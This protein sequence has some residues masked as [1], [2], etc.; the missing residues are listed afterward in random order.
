MERRGFLG[1]RDVDCSTWCKSLTGQTAQLGQSPALVPCEWTRLQQENCL[2]QLHPVTERAEFKY[3]S[4][5]I[6]DVKRK[7]ISQYWWVNTLLFLEITN[8]NHHGQSSTRPGT[9]GHCQD[10]TEGARPLP[11]A[12][13]PQRC[14]GPVLTGAAAPVLREPGPRAQHHQ[15]L[16][17]LFTSI[18][19]VFLYRVFLREAFIRCTDRLAAKEV[20]P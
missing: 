15:I 14:S 13:Q 7:H 4:T 17:S 18:I 19:L 3:C 11:L 2:L 16:V 20:F 9:T 1:S 12:H 5:S 8:L 10:G 6:M